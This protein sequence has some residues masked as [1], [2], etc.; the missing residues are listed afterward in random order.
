MERSAPPAAG[1]TPGAGSGAGSGTGPRATARR[2]GAG[3]RGAIPGGRQ[4]AELQPSWTRRRAARTVES[5]NF[6]G[7]RRTASRN[8]QKRGKRSVPRLRPDWWGGGWAGPR[9]A[10]GLAMSGV[11]HGMTQVKGGHLGEEVKIILVPPSPATDW[12]GFAVM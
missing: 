8:F 11:H 7:P 9:G 4:G 2:A 12:W 1:R 3:D 10:R 5:C 6:P